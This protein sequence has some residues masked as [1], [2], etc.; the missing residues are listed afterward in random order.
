LYYKA[1]ALA[2]RNCHKLRYASSLAPSAVGRAR[3]ARHKL[4]TAMGGEPGID[5][6]ERR[7]GTR[8]KKYARQIIKLGLVTKAHYEQLRAFLA[9]SS[10]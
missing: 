8:R 10:R 1:G 7:S 9:R 5:V 2:C 3:L 4:M 6:P